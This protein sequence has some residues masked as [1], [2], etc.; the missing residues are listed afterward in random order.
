M[1][2]SNESWIGLVREGIAPNHDRF[3]FGRLYEG[4]LNVRNVPFWVD[5][6]L[7]TAKD[8]IW[9]TVIRPWPKPRTQ[10]RPG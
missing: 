3:M 4:Q 5:E 9:P 8:T 7:S 6:D 1:I 10:P 2:L